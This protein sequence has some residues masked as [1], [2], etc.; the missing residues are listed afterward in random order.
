MIR[1]SEF[2]WTSSIYEFKTG[3]LA[4]SVRKSPSVWRALYSTPS[5]ARSLNRNSWEIILSASTWIKAKFSFDLERENI[6][7]FQVYSPKAPDV[8]DI[9]TR[10]RH[11]ASQPI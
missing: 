7:L 11:S 2:F 3:S 4:G 5:Y 1:Q 8:R 6:L 9:L 10:F